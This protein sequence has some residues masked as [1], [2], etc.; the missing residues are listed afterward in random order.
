MLGDRVTQR[1]RPGID[2]PYLLSILAVTT[3]FCGFWLWYTVPNFATAD[4][5]SR[6]I[7]P[8]KVA[9]YTLADPGFSSLQRGVLDG[10]ALGASTY[11]YLLVFGPVGLYVLL[12]GQLGTFASFSGLQ[13]RWDLWFAVPDWFW[14][15]SILTARLTVVAFAVGCTYVLYRLGCHLGDRTT[16]RLAAVFLGLSLGFI[17]TAHEAGEDI[18]ALFA[19]LLAFLFLFRYLDRGDRRPL[20]IASAVGGIAIAL[21]LTAGVIVFVIGAAVLARAREGAH[22]RRETLAHSAGGVLIGAVVIYLGFPSALVGGPDELIAR[23]TAAGG[24]KAAAQNGD[25]IWVWMLQKY[26]EGIGIPLVVAV[27]AGTALTLTE[28]PDRLRAGEYKSALLVVALAVYLLVFSRWGYIRVHH[29]LPTLPLLYLLTAETLSDRLSWPDYNLA[30]AAVAV[31]VVSTALFA[32]VGTAAYTAEP[33]DQAAAWL[34][35]NAESDATVEVYEQSIADVGMP[36]HLN[37]SRYDYN[38]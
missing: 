32:G 15:A 8:M 4:E 26:V 22:T 35:E 30:T 20:W 33:R 21:K 31:L 24:Q 14:T 10:R 9:G 36:H 3:V 2:D 13:S 38:E 27:V 34:D 19:F 7:R 16:G 11:L 28:M 1:L 18:P 29:L 23:V 17:S 12:S 6:L 37:V 5:Y 25:P